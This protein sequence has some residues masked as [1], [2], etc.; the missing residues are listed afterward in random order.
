MMKRCT[1]WFDG[2]SRNQKQWCWFVFLWCA[3]FLCVFTL[4]KI[5]RISMGIDG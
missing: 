3:G 5:I 4:A 1:K 2:L